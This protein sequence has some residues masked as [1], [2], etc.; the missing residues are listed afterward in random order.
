MH[1][2]EGIIQHLLAGKPAWMFQDSIYWTVLGLLGNVMFSSR[3]IVQWFHSETHQRVVVPGVF[4][5]ISFWASLICLVYAVHVDKLPILLSYIF[6]PFVYGRNLALLRK[7][8][9]ENVSAVQ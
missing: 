5:H 9:A 8:Q 2:S 4:W 1:D 3:F 6:L 7:S